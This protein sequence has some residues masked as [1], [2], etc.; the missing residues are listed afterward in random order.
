MI[1]SLFLILQLACN[2]DVKIKSS[3]EFLTVTLHLNEKHQT[4]SGFGAS[5]AWS[6]QFVGSNWPMSKKTQ[7]ADWLFSLATDNENNPLGIGLTSWRFNFGAG[8]AYQGV[9]SDIE[10]EWRRAESFLNLDGSFNPQAHTGQ[11]WF[12]NAAKERG[13]N[14]FIAFVNS[15]PI[16]LTKNGKAYSSG[17]SSANIT[18]ENY[19]EF[20]T[21]LI[22]AL[23]EIK[24]SHGISFRYL[25]PFNEPQWDWNG[26]GQEG[27][28][29]NNIEMSAMLKI[30]NNDLVASSHINTL[31]EI[32][33]AAQLNFLYSGDLNSGRDDQVDAF[34]NPSNTSTYIGNISRVT[35]KVAG[36]S[37]FTTWPLTNFVETRSKLNQKLGEYSTLGFE[38]TEYCPLEN[39][40]DIV[41]NGRDLGMD[42]ALYG[43]RVMHVDLT[44]AD[45]MSWSWWLAISPYDY[46]DGLVYIDKSTTDGRVFDSKMLWALG[47]YSRFVRPGYQRVT[48]SRSDLRTVEQTLE[49]VMVSAFVDP[50]SNKTVSV[51]INHTAN[52]VPLNIELLNN[53][54]RS[55]KYY[56][57]SDVPEE[58]LKYMGIYTSGSP[59]DIPP[60][61]ITTFVQQD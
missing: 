37:Y 42:L 28:P 10:D 9:S 19:S 30:L 14:Q 55:W 15:P 31:I 32:P 6:T 20:S 26:A 50:I 44:V 22:R 43:A 2:D 1:F 54:N 13:V 3:N 38:M 27:S 12:L 16:S 51:V 21:M 47:N 23:D 46:K 29:W 36:H 25:S 33:E 58:D 41:G 53:K 35:K 45:A 49:G 24:N 5:D 48:V 34:F 59:T 8:S 39:N 60:R 52:N 11:R 18:S 56:R 17:G 57:T 4:I 61:S 7:I 40:A